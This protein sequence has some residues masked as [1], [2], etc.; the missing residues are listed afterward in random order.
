METVEKERLYSSILQSIEQKLHQI[1]D[2]TAQ[3]LY[4]VIVNQLSSIPYFNWTGI[5]LVNKEKNELELDYYV[6]KTTEHTHIPIGRGVCGSA[7][8]DKT[9]KIVEDVT[10]E[11]NYLACSLE[12]R[13]EIVVLIEDGAQIIGQIDVD[14]DTIA[15][16]D[17][18]DRKYLRQIAELIF[19]NLNFQST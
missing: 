13:S 12:T 5:Y 16:F 6:G 14:S 10:L 18:I 2:I 15:A 17:E 4:M 1:G 3:K 19:E 9:D 11:D 7:V 8:A